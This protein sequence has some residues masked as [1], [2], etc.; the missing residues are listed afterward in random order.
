MSFMW[1]K[2]NYNDIFAWIIKSCDFPDFVRTYYVDHI[3]YA[4]TLPL[5]STKPVYLAT[6][7]EVN[8]CDIILVMDWNSCWD[9]IP[10]DFV[11]IVNKTWDTYYELLI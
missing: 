1:V 10:L 8:S 7:E 3:L 11:E 6:L 5:F 4:Y 9:D 2:I